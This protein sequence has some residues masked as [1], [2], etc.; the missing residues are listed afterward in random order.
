[1]APYQSS[2]GHFSVWKGSFV[3]DSVESDNASGSGFHVVAPHAHVLLSGHYVVL[4]YLKKL[5]ICAKSYSDH[6]ISEQLNT[7]FIWILGSMG[8]RYSNGKV[9]WLGGPFK[10]QTFWTINRLIWSSFQTTILLPDHF[11]NLPFEYQT[12][13]VLRW[14][15]YHLNTPNIRT[16]DLSDTF[17]SRF[18]MV[19][20]CD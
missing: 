18:Q 8:V 5:G 11:T 6:L 14:L 19:C 16:Y 20:S 13:L 10:Y 12:S 15:L 4:K 17:L 9:R 3:I 2:A 7:G 1:M